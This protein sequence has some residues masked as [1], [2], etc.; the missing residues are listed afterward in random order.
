MEDIS[1]NDDLYSS[2]GAGLVHQDEMALPC[3]RRLVSLALS[4]K[5]AL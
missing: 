3:N 4:R 5:W 2:Y 1:I